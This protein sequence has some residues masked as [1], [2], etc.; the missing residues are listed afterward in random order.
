[1]T[2][3]QLD[4]HWKAR[5]DVDV[6]TSPSGS[7]LGRR[8]HTGPLRVQRPFFPEG[9]EV[10]HV[11]PIH[12][13]G[14]VVG[15]DCLETHLRVSE[16][17]HALVTTPAAQKIY[18]SASLPSELTTELIL[19]G[20]ARAE[21]LPMET[22]VFDGA[23]AR[24]RSVIHLGDRARYIG[25][26]IVCFGRPA[27][28]SRFASGLFLSSLEVFRCDRPLLVENTRVEGGCSVLDSSWG[29]AG[30]P[31]SATWLCVAS[32]TQVLDGVTRQLGA[33]RLVGSTLRAAATRLDG[34]VI[35]R[36]QSESVEAARRLL[37]ES[38]VQSRPLVMGRPACPPR[39]WET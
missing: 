9:R 39:I 16:S 27:A 28:G 11:Y 24:S 18:R 38:W 32:D 37:I 5:L 8:T 15:G 36:I 34:S 17:A 25:W 33:M 10:L 29:Y 2:Q 14:G 13:P 1:M 12:P 6:V 7:R 20:D 30:Y 22:I 26:E 23:R 4:S 31:I 35:L 19:E 3:P 21:W